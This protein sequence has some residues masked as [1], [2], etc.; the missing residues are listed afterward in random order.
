MKKQTR[1]ANAISTGLLVMGVVLV[2]AWVV[3]MVL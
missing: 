2:L 3:W 1:L